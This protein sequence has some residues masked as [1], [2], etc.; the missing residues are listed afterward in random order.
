MKHKDTL[1]YQLHKD[2]FELISEVEALKFCSQANMCDFISNFEFPIGKNRID[3][4]K[5]PF[6]LELKYKMLLFIDQLR[7]DKLELL[8]IINSTGV[9]K[10]IGIEVQVLRL[11]DLLKCVKMLIDNNQINSNNRFES[12]CNYYDYG[13]II[14]ETKE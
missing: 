2:E 4:F 14:K 9:Y 11:E 8:G 12:I 6:Q 7:K 5:D 10:I 1:V 13:Y 3:S